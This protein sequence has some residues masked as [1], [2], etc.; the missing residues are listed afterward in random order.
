MIL[1]VEN[2]KSTTNMHLRETLIEKVLQ[3]LLEFVEP[4]FELTEEEEKELNDEQKREAEVQFKKNLLSEKK[5][6][7]L[8]AAE[9]AQLAFDD[10]LV[11][12]AFDAG[13]EAIKEQWDPHKDTDLV[14]AQCK[15]NYVI[16]E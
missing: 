5:Q 3:Q 1:D 7:V 16:A 2:A 9:I 8:L 4:E 14:I 12:I 15:A 6:R 10:N 13:K 11:E